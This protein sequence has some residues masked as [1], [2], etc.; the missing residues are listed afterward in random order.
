M[1]INID[2]EQIV[3]DEYGEYKYANSAN[4]V[5]FTVHEVVP[6]KIKPLGYLFL[7]FVGFISFVFNFS[8]IF[9]SSYVKSPL[10][11]YY[12]K[13]GAAA[14][15]TAAP[16]FGFLLFL[17]CFVFFALV[18]VEQFQFFYIVCKDGH[19]FLINDPDCLIFS[20]W[21]GVSILEFLA[22]LVSEVVY[23]RSRS[24]YVQ[25]LILYLVIF[26][27]NVFAQLNVA[28]YYNYGIVLGY[29]QFSNFVAHSHNQR[30]L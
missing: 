2:D 21:D 22:S 25:L 20:K 29:D 28:C 9:R 30:K 18:I 16:V 19:I 12:I 1:K 6:N 8:V 5:D 11:R 26:C 7:A 27:V 23:G 14:F 10:L 17:V 4:I 24:V 15:C 13:T 3:I